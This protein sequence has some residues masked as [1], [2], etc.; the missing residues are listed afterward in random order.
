MKDLKTLKRLMLGLTSVRSEALMLA[1]WRA[2]KWA[3][4]VLIV[5]VSMLLVGLGVLAFGLGSEWARA[6]LTHLR[7]VDS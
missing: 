1:V 3:V 2:D 5:A 7:A 4:N 6:G